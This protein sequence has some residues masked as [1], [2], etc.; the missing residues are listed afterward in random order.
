M[1]VRG[2]SEGAGGKVE[3]AFLLPGAHW[4][5]AGVV[6]VSPPLVGTNTGTAFKG[7]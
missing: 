7:E 5:T 6:V 2:E 4:R 3:G 1:K